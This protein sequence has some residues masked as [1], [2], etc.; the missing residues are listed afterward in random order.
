MSFLCAFQ[1][2]PCCCYTSSWRIVTSLSRGSGHISDYVTATDVPLLVT[3]IVVGESIHRI[4][5][6]ELRRVEF[7]FMDGYLRLINKDY[8]N[9]VSRIN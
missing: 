6:S 5:C 4:L 3:L 7:C 2:I 8:R 9:F 1:Q